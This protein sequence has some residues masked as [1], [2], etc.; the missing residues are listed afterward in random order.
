MPYANNGETK[1]YWEEYGAGEPLLLIMGLGGSRREWRRLL[2]ALSA[3]YRVIVFD[4]RGVGETVA[5]DEA[6]SI[7][8]MASDAKAVLEAANVESAHVL[9]M[10][11]G[12]MIAQEFALHYPE[13]TRSL[14]LTVTNCGGREA[15][16]AE[17][18][19][20]FALQ[21]RGVATP[22]DAFWA[23]APYIYAAKTPRERLAE[24]LAAREGVFT[25][26]ENFMR[27]LQAIMSWQGTFPR[28][29]NIKVP[30]LVIGGVNDR[31]IPC[32]NSKILADAIPNAQLV[33]LEDS[34]HIFPTDQPEK[35]IE[36]ILEFLGKP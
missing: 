5:N 7:P 25:K 2:P 27:Q 32:A 11:M 30:T 17:L 22:E 18:E 14:I 34:S 3:E 33:E 13:M 6:F 10:S 35:S 9:G 1:I 23:M 24:D 20:Y 12:G 8:L 31:L 21:G 16:P 15:V 4:N 28:L 36:V 29:L 26:P 19:V